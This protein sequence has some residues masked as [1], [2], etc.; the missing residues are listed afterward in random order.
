MKT[1]EVKLTA[2]VKAENADN[3]SLAVLDN[4]HADYRNDDIIPEATVTNIT[5]I[6]KQS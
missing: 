5:E 6:E 2:I 1:Y 3:A 4:L